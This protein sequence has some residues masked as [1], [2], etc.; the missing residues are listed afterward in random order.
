MK[1]KA[2]ESLLGSKNH[3]WSSC[4]KLEQDFLTHSSFK[5][6]VC[7][8]PDGGGSSDPLKCVGL[9]L[10]SNHRLKKTEDL[11]SHLFFLVRTLKS[12]DFLSLSVLETTV[13]RTIADGESSQW[14]TLSNIKRTFWLY[15]HFKVTPNS[16]F[17]KKKNNNNLC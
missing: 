13:T 10:V 7:E 11:P 4:F 3:Y 17:K 9:S 5:P 12:M 2:Y 14:P 15:A 1:F 6:F 8:K 16:D